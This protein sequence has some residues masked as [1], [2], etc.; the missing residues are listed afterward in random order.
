MRGKNLNQ[1][2]RTHLEES[3]TFVFGDCGGGGGGGGGIGGGGCIYINPIYN[4]SVETDKG[5]LFGDD[6]QLPF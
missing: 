1:W 6:Q 4:I 2:F 5:N 3:P